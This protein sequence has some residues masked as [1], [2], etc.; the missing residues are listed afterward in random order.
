MMNG[1]RSGPTSIALSM[2]HFF[3][4]VR[5]HVLP[6]LHAMPLVPD[7][8]IFD[9]VRTVPASMDACVKWAVRQAEDPNGHARLGTQ[10]NRTEINDSPTNNR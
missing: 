8:V 4:L 7:Y 1:R 9:H 10:L 5:E 6:V 3:V 2:V